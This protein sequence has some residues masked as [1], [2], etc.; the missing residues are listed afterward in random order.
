MFVAQDGAAAEI[1]LFLKSAQADGRSW[2]SFI[3]LLKCLRLLGYCVAPLSDNSQTQTLK[4][5]K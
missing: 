2:F 1:Q 4:T 5:F 3:F